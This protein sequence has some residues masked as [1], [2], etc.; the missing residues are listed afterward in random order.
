VRQ[1]EHGA[2]AGARVLGDGGQAIAAR[3]TNRRAVGFGL[4]AVDV[5]AHH[6]GPVLIEP[7]GRRVALEHQV[8]VA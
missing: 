2:D 7:V 8:G 5:N 6:R 1:G 3:V 4:Q